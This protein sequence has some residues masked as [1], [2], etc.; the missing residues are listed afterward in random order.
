MRVVVVGASA[1]GLTTVETLRSDGFDGE[2]TLI[3][4][5]RHLPY[6]RPPLSKAVLRGDRE[7]SELALLPADRWQRLELDLRLGVAATG[8]DTGRR[9]VSLADGEAV[10]YDRLVIATGARPRRL[11]P[12]LGAQGVHLF[13]TVDDAERLRERARSARRMVIIGAGFLG[14]EIAA[15]LTEQGVPVVLVDPGPGPLA[16]LGPELSAMIADLHR[17]HGVDLRCGVGVTSLESH[18]DGRVARLSDGSTVTTDCVVAAIGAEPVTDWLAGSGL[19][20]ADGVVCD[21]RLRAAPDVYAAGDVAA[22]PDPDGGRMLR[23]E[24]RM[25]ATEQA[26]RVA[27]NLL[28]ADE[29]FAPTP[30]FW[31]D[32]YDLKLQSYGI[33]RPEDPRQV[34]QGSLA[35]RR[36]V[37]LVR[38]GDRI[39]GA[40]GCGMPRDLLRY[41]RLVA[42]RASWSEA[43][44]NPDEV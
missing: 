36:F 42:A 21:D 14:T 24:H 43:V 16:V 19:D 44:A 35:D 27:R 4:A 23:I 15:S 18:S 12:S 32:Q 33:F 26:I 28:G 8:L 6:D 37:M 11:P 22:W 13:R 40:I 34:V 25:N 20:L 17:D 29:P 3:G 9:T 30:Y 1:A 41:R 31:T 7:G 10:A 39:A 38:R 2:L 5:E